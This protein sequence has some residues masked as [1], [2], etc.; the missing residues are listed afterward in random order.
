MV[1]FLD[2]IDEFA[3]MLSEESRIVIVEKVEVDAMFTAQEE[4]GSEST[5]VRSE[6]CERD[7][8]GGHDRN[9]LTSRGNHGL[10]SRLMV[11]GR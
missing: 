6:D 11:L 9:K 3:D 8:T 7:S 2:L 5:S 10:L 4:S 1:D